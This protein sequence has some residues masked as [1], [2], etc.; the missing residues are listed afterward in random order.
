M[1]GIVIWRKACTNKEE[2]SRGRY[3]ASSEWFPLFCL[4]CSSAYFTPTP[5]LSD[6]SSMPWHLPSSDKGARRRLN[7][8]VMVDQALLTFSFSKKYFSLPPDPCQATC[9][10]GEDITNNVDNYP[11]QCWKNDRRGGRDRFGGGFWHC[12][13]EVLC[14]ILP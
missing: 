4:L 5:P 9:K 10:G 6:V 8:M 3:T 2:N 1:N 11:R 13:K 14:Q 12:T 7:E